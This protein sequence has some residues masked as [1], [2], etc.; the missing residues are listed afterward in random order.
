MLLIFSTRR[1][2]STLR[3]LIDRF[4]FVSINF[5]GGHRR[6]ADCSINSLSVNWHSIDCI[7]ELSGILDL[8]TRVSVGSTAGFVN[9]NDVKVSSAAD[10]R[11]KKLA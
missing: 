6:S 5:S 7:L 11:W 3:K 1:S 4:K 10:F 8:L 9:V 2:L